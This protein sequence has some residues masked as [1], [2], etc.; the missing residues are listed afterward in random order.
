LHL[1]PTEPKDFCQAAVRLLKVRCGLCIIKAW[2]VYAILLYWQQHY[3]CYLSG[4]AR[5][6]A[7]TTADNRTFRRTWY[8]FNKIKCRPTIT[9]KCCSS[10]LIS[11]QNFRL[12]KQGQLLGLWGYPTLTH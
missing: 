5:E 11:Y 10:M 3:R 8:T 6:L 1:G 12:G 7:V 4:H 9:R 2:S